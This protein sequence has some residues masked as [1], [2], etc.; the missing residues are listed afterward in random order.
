MIRFNGHCPGLRAVTRVAWARAASSADSSTRWRNG[1]GMNGGRQLD[2]SV[3]A[4]IMPVS[5][6]GKVCGVCNGGCRRYAL[7]TASPFYSPTG[8]TPFFSLILYMRLLWG[9]FGKIT[10]DIMGENGRRA[11]GGG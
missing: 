9:V 1:G 10:L 8:V 3:N 6:G 5:R 2:T 7:L 4:S 11:A